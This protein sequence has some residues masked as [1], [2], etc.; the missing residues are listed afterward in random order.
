MFV[1]YET[2]N[3]SHKCIE[4]CADLSHVF[5]HCSLP[6]VFVNEDPVLREKRVSLA[7]R[8]SSVDRAS[9]YNEFYCAVKLFNATV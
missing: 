8:D 1:N 6:P 4:I 9:I 3:I 2:R 7:V 5:L